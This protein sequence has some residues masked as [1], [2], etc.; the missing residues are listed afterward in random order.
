MAD[1]SGR[2]N[3][4]LPSYIEWAGDRPELWFVYHR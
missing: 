2:N 1:A 3:G 4:W